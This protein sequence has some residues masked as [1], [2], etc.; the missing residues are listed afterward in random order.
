MTNRVW[1]A[2][3]LAGL[4]LAVAACRASSVEPAEGLAT[5]RARWARNAPAS[6]SYTI[7]R[8]CECLTEAAGPVTVVVRNGV[9]ESRTYVATGAAV[10]AQYASIFPAVE[11]LFAMIDDA[12]RS[13]TTPLTTRYDPTL[14]Y[15]TRI[16]LGDPAVDAPLYLVSNLVPR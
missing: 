14:G 6:Y 15:P 5:A 16:A 3:T 11:G 13:G 4:V 12:I 7:Q 10:A 2:I 9:V 8:S 1:K